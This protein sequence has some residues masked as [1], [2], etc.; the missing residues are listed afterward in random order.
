MLIEGELEQ[1]SSIVEDS[2]TAEAIIFSAGLELIDR[3]DHLSGYPKPTNRI[4]E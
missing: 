2:F 1:V 3:C 4:L